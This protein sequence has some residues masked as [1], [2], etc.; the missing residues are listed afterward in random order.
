MAESKRRC[1]GEEREGPL[2]KGDPS[3]VAHPVGQRKGMRP[4][5]VRWPVVLFC[6]AFSTCQSQNGRSYHL[7]A[8]PRL[9]VSLC[10]GQPRASSQ[11]V[12]GI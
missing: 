12:L 6:P 1:V 7:R 10:P 2:R 8:T 4:S 5:Q 9:K 11:V 3:P